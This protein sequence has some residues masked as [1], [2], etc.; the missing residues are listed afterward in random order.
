MIR[1]DGN[2]SFLAMCDGCYDC[3]FFDVADWKA[4]MEAMKKRG[5]WKSRRRREWFH[6]CPECVRTGRYR[7]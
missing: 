4:L 1:R 5:W 3:K 6:F 7:K 2:G